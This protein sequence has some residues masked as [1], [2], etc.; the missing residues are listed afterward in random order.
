MKRGG[1]GDEFARRGA[2]YAHLDRHLRSATRFFAAAALVNEAF[3]YLFR[4]L[5]SG[6]STSSYAFLSE[7][8][9]S[10]EPLNLYYARRIRGGCAAGPW[11][12]RSLVRLEQRHVQRC[13]HWWAAQSGAVAW[14]RAVH[15]LNGLLNAYYPMALFA[16][17]LSSGGHLLA[18]VSA[19]RKEVGN[20]LDFANGSHRVRIGC[21]LI[22]Q[23][24]NH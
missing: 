4:R 7:L 14:N 2:L 13:W 18:A 19:V 12:D 9:A 21:A 17:L 16:P 11:L 1:G 3:A 22:Q 20:D 10:L 6:I 5:P 24:R 15:E 8:G 23:I